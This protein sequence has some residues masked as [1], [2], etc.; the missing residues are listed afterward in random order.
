MSEARLGGDVAG[1]ARADS[2]L[3]VA[4]RTELIEVDLKRQAVLPPRAAAFAS[5]QGITSLTMDQHTIWLVGEGGV[6][7]IHRATGRSAILP[8]GITLSTAPTDVALA[9]DIAWIG[10]RNGL[11]RVRRRA[12]GMPP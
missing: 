5:L 11:V 1:I 10:T 12:D 9:T 8:V 7:A 6:M 2:V 4:T 3:A